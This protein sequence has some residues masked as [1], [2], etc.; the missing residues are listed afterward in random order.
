M[1]RW[2][3]RDR[4][5]ERVDPPK[6]KKKDSLPVSDSAV[7][8]LALRWCLRPTLGAVLIL[9]DWLEQSLRTVGAWGNLLV[10]IEFPSEFCVFSAS[11]VIMLTKYSLSHSCCERDSESGLITVGMVFRIAGVIF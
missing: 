11:L 6:K 1:D 4:R 8:D 5:C 10:R 3:V 9:Q 7:L 2:S